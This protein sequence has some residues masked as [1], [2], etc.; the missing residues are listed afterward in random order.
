MLFLPFVT[1]Y[2]YFARLMLFCVRPTFIQLAAIG[3]ELDVKCCHVLWIS[4]KYC[5]I[6]VFLSGEYSD[7]SGVSGKRHFSLD[8]LKI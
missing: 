3:M 6:R 4:F 7:S 8:D 5:E 2:Y 1:Y